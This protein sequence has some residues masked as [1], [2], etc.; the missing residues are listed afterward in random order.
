M[1]PAERAEIDAAIARRPAGMSVWTLLKILH[2]GDDVRAAAYGD[3]ASAIPVIEHMGC[4]EFFEPLVSWQQHPLPKAEAVAYAQACID[5][6]C[7]AS[8]S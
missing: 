3:D 2:G 7:G 8:P 6:I 5:K 1:S 4:R